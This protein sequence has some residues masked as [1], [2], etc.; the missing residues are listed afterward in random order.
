M[1][2]SV[3]LFIDSSHARGL[4]E[5]VKFEGNDGCSGKNTPSVDQDQET[6]QQD[7]DCEKKKPKMQFTYS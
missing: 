5:S 1:F 7:K 4:I 3:I 6:M 2:T